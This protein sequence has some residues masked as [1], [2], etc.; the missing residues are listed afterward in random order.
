MRENLKG[1]MRL[2]YQNQLAEKDC[3][4]K[5]QENRLYR[6]QKEKIEIQLN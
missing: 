3:D 2:D 6:K 4:S 5:Q 1:R